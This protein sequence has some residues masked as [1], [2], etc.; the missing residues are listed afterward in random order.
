M[1]EKQDKA[2]NI[3]MPLNKSTVHIPLG[4]CLQFW[5]ISEA[6]MGRRDGQESSIASIQGMGKLAKAPQ[7]DEEMMRGLGM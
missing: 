5:S 6:Q 7:L 1:K 2:E 3:I 4:N